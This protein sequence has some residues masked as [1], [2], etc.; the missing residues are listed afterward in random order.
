[1]VTVRNDISVGIGS[2]PFDVEY[3]R[4]APDKHHPFIIWILPSDI[5]QNRFS[6]RIPCVETGAFAYATSGEQITPQQSFQFPTALALNNNFDGLCTC[7]VAVSQSGQAGA[8]FEYV[9]AP[10]YFVFDHSL[11]RL[12]NATKLTLTSNV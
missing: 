9:S 5:H 7:E 4:V 6:V 11:N 10:L 3:S 1:M 2:S 8:D 12:F